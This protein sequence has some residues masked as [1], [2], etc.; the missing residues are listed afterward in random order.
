MT[1][2][3]IKINLENDGYKITRENLFNINNETL[4][5]FFEIFKKEDLPNHGNFKNIKVVKDLN[6]FKFLNKIFNELIKILQSNNINY[7]FEDVW[8]QKSEYINSRP[9]ELPFIPHIDKHR[10]F[11]IMVYL[12]NVHRDSGPIHFIKCRPSDYENFRKKLSKTYQVD[13]E[14]EIKDFDISKYENC[15]GPTGTII[16]FDTNCPHFAG[17]NKDGKTEPRYIYRFNFILK[18]KK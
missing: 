2:V 16:F 9:G 6:Q 3:N 15:S 18:K 13:K 1:D 17:I 5:E 8:A 11:K 4:D 14:N 10:K 12:N 7:I